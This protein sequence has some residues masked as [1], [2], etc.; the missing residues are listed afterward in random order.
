MR[1]CIDCM[2]GMMCFCSGSAARLNE[3]RL[4][5]QPSDQVRHHSLTQVSLILHVHFQTLLFAHLC[6][7]EIRTFKT[8]T[9]QTLKHTTYSY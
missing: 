8:G 3:E 1:Y 9:I 4:V 6:P 5:T 7:A 2:V